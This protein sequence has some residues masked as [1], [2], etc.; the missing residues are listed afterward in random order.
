MSNT[1]ESVET[2]TVMQTQQAEQPLIALVDYQPKL[3]TN[4]AYQ[5]LLATLPVIVRQAKSILAQPIDKLDDDAFAEI[6]KQLKE[7]LATGKQIEKA[8]KAIRAQYDTGKKAAEKQ[9]VAE[10][11]AAGY[12]ELQAISDKNKLM[13]QEA[14][15]RRLESRWQELA[16]HWH[17]LVSNVYIDADPAKSLATR[18]PNMTFDRWRQQHS[19]LLSGAKT[20][21]VRENDKQLITDYLNHANSDLKALLNLK[22]PFEPDILNYYQLTNDLAKTLAHN[23]QLIQAKAAADAQAKL[24]TK[25]A[26]IQKANQA[27]SQ[28]VPTAQT[29][30]ATQ[31]TVSAQATAS[32]Q[33]INT[34]IQYP[35]RTKLAAIWGI[36]QQAASG[37]MDETTSAAI[38]AEIR[39]II[40]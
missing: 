16:A 22:S 35:N 24:A 34:A 25:Q 1:T 31:Q 6:Q 37:P 8:L 5:R 13:R 14:I 40:A 33:A 36:M 15:N 29:N 3:Q 23:T 26:I 11:N 18:F 28:I 4:P 2:V 39:Q 19:N 38:L 32:K 21:K 27:S 12:D 20:K 9:I 7:P 10:L 17:Q 30:P